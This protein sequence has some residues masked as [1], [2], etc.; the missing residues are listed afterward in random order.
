MSTTF[1][2][3][4][5]MK[6]SQARLIIEDSFKMNYDS[7]MMKREDDMIA[8][9]TSIAIGFVGKDLTKSIHADAQI[10]RLSKYTLDKQLNKHPNIM[11]NGV[12]CYK[13]IQQLIDNGLVIKEG[14]NNYNR[15]LLFLGEL[16]D[17]QHKTKL[18]KLA[19]KVTENR[20]EIYLSSLHPIQ[21]HL[22]QN[23]CDNGVLIRNKI[24][25]KFIK[26]NKYIFI[27]TIVAVFYYYH[28][29]YH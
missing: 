21:A 18:Y 24:K 4:E 9:N 13:N 15:V 8:L 3:L 28:Y 26:S 7:L 29:H 10:I 11:S 5:S 17:N 16:R 27:L 1:Q 19:I 23:I 22:K 12:F 14:R 20:D 25:L 6:E 2:Y